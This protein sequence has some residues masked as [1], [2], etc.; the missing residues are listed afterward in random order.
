VA[1]AISINRKSEIPKAQTP[2]NNLQLRTG[3]KELIS[4]NYKENPSERE[5]FEHLFAL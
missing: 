1:V 2:A 3:E 5:N 4:L